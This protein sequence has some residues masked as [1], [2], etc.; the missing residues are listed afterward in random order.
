MRLIVGI[1][2]I[3]LPLA[4]GLDLTAVL[5]IIMSLFSFCLVWENVT[6]LRRDAQFWETWENTQPP[7]RNLAV[8]NPTEASSASK[9]QR[10]TT[11]ELSA[12][13]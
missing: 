5:S 12:V 2:I 1:T 11:V 7:E 6:A 13:A 8:C 4:K 3:V 10:D 9:E